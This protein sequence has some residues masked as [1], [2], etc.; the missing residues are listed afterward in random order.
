MLHELIRV[1][2]RGKGGKLILNQ[3]LGSVSEPSRGDTTKRGRMMKL[4]KAPRSVVAI[5]V[6]ALAFL[7]VGP[8]LYAQQ[9]TGNIFGE[10][11]DE[12]GGRLPGVMVTI[13]GIGAPKTQ[14]TDAIGHF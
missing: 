8:A 6:V 7:I 5:A 2:E 9:L 10:V 3:G 13:S 12:Q 11:T 4:L 14:T 1:N